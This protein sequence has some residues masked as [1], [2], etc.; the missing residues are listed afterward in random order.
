MPL[1][2]LSDSE[3]LELEQSF[4]SKNMVERGGGGDGVM[5]QLSSVAVHLTDFFY[6]HIQLQKR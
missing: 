6:T 5:T 3:L 1:S 4:W 2:E